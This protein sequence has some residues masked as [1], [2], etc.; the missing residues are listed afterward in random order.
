[1]IVNVRNLKKEVLIR[2]TKTSDKQETAITATVIAK[3]KEKKKHSM[4]SNMW[5]N[6]LKNCPA[7]G[8][9]YKNCKQSNNFAKM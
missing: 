6:Y 7:T 3:K 4:W 1:M 2:R 8:K 9:P 5:R